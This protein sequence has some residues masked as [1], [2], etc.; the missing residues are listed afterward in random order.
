LLNTRATAAN[1][2]TPPGYSMWVVARIAMGRAQAESHHFVARW[3]VD[4][5]QASSE[6][7][8]ALR[9]VFGRA[10]EGADEAECF[11]QFAVG[12]FDEPG[13]DR[14]GDKLDALSCCKSCTICYESTGW[15]GH[16]RAACCWASPPQERFLSWGGGETGV[17][18]FA[19]AMWNTSREYCLLRRVPCNATSAAR[20]LRGAARSRE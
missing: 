8:D 12:R 6:A 5:Y 3:R 1:L 7:L 15:A 14:A 2:S 17:H 9:V 16:S 18:N 19:T 11:N 20:G 10:R 4:T 13:L